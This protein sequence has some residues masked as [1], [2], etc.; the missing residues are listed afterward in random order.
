MKPIHHYCGLTAAFALALSFASTG[1]GAVDA[2]ASQA[3]QEMQK[4][5]FQVSA[6]D[7]KIWNLTLN[8][9]KNVQ[10]ELG[11]KNVD[12]EIVAYGPGIGMLKF[13]SAVANRIDEAVAEGVK[14]VACEN[15]MKAQKL[16]KDDMLSSAGFVPA[17]VI[18]LMKKQKEGYAYIRP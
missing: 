18:E 5:V 3:S 14:V 16:S 15:T 12:I 4:V 8:N 6:G 2:P 9:A 7:P 13:D 10:Q 17:G 11:A 1:A